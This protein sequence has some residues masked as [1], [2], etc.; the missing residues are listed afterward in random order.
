MADAQQLQADIEA[1][2]EALDVTRSFIVQAPAGSGK[3]EL[4]IQRYLCL[5]GTVNEPEE[6][7]AITFT[8]KAASEMQA[9][10]IEALQKASRG[11]VAEQPHEQ[12]TQAA[13]LRILERDKERRWQL[14]ELPRRMRIQT[15]DAFCSSITRLLPVSSGIGGGMTTTADAGMGR[16]Y[17]EA[18]AATLDWLSDSTP[19]ASAVERVL[20]HLDNNV[21]SYVRYL[22]RMLAKR[23]QW[24]GIIGI[25]TGDNLDDVRTALEATIERQVCAQLQQLRQRMLSLGGPAELAL[26]RYAGVNLEDDALQSLDRSD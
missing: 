17:K 23:E 15:L 14:L 16:L 10:V 19:A 12:V 26:I 1:R 4:L 21:H 6:V 5:L 20:G 9:R 13:A 24:L 18:A 22:A 11:E 25:G 2:R 7:V 8:R 3:T